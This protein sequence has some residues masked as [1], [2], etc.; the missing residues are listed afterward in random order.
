MTNNDLQKITQNTIEKHEP[1]R[2]E[3]L[4][5]IIGPWEKEYTGTPTYTTTRV[6]KTVN[7]YKIK[8]I[9]IVLVLP[10]K[11]VLKHKKHGMHNIHMSLWGPMLM[12]PRATAQRAHALKRHCPSE[13]EGVLTRL[14]W[15]GKQLLLK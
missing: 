7:V 11:S 3:R 4:N 9:F 12:N 14:L 8:N 2:Q 6:N 15:K 10:T 5:S 13:R 1:H